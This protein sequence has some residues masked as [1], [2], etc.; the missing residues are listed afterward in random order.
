MRDHGAT[1]HRYCE[2]MLGAEGAAAL[3]PTILGHLHEHAHAVEPGDERRLVLAVAHNRCIERSRTGGRPPAGQG[4]GDDVAP[5]VRALALLRPVGR[6]ALV[7]RSGLGLRWAELERVCGVPTERLVVRT[8]RA[9]RNVATVADGGRPGPGQRPK[10]RRLDD[11]PAAWAAIREDARRF[12]ALRRALREVLEGYA[13]APGWLEDAWQRLEQEQA[14]QREQAALR[15][16]ERAAAARAEAEQLAAQARAAEATASG[17][18][19]SGS[20]VDEDEDELEPEPEPA[21]RPRSW[22]WLAAGVVLA[23]VGLAARWLVLR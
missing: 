6:D 18:A 9:W 2:A 17:G 15:A 8:C 13:P 20:S 7:L 1:L 11:D 12:V 21:A 16:A 23:L 5:M 14:E 10:G 3:L 19:F 22:R 4:L